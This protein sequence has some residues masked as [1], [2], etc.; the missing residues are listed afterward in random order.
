MW[1]S[2]IGSFGQLL[3]GGPLGGGGGLFP[4]ARTPQAYRGANYLAQYKID[5]DKFR[6]PTSYQIFPSILRM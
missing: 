6:T 5:M 3:K 1:G 4:G 2:F